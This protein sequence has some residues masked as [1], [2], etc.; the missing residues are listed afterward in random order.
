MMEDLELT[1]VVVVSCLIFIIKLLQ[2]MII[3]KNVDI[4]SSLDRVFQNNSIKAYMLAVTT[5]HQHHMINIF[6]LSPNLG[7]WVK[8]RSIVWFSRFLFTKYDDDYWVQNFTMTKGI[9]FDIVNRVR[10]IVAK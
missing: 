4:F 7:H 5:L 9:L 10:P 2:Q 1:N 6:S 8:P 3:K